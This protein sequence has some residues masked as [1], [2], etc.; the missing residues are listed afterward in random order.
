MLFMRAGCQLRIWP[1]QALN[2][3]QFGNEVHA[4]GKKYIYNALHNLKRVNTHAP[5]A[6]DENLGLNIFIFIRTGQIGKLQATGTTKELKNPSVLCD[7][8]EGLNFHG[9]F[10]CCNN[11]RIVACLT[12]RSTVLF[13]H[14]YAFHLYLRIGKQ[15]SLT[16]TIR[17]SP[18]IACWIRGQTICLRIYKTPLPENE[19]PTTGLRLL[20]LLLLSY[21]K[22][23][24]NS[25][26]GLLQ[27]FSSYRD[28][29]LKT[30]LVK[31]H[32]KK[33]CIILWNSLHCFSW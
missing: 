10:S 32:L 5:H 8:T 23:S 9:A 2:V 15:C 25:P 17:V 27:S 30:F 16:L 1:L 33:T 31:K 18:I 21:Q 3:Q 24:A 13:S 29:I 6:Q 12:V 28:Y 4:I 20:S 22:T 11:K 26:D 19:S 14:T 7:C